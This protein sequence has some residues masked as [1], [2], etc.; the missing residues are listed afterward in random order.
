MWLNLTVFLFL[1]LATSQESGQTCYSHGMQHVQISAT[2]IHSRVTQ[3]LRKFRK[4]ICKSK[5][6]FYIWIFKYNTCLIRFFKI[7]LLTSLVL[8]TKKIFLCLRAIWLCLSLCDNLR[9]SCLQPTALKQI[10]PI[11]LRQISPRT[12]G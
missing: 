5:T 6:K 12:V 9:R 11:F 7:V 4:V 10:R 2:L 8:R 1:L 3:K